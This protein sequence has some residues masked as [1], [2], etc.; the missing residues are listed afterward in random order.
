M[1]QT[2]AD[3]AL[4]DGRSILSYIS[5]TIDTETARAAAITH[6]H[7]PTDVCNLCN[8]FKVSIN[9]LDV[10]DPV[11]NRS[12]TNWLHQFFFLILTPDT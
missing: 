3:F 2:L 6:I 5:K 11:D 4:G 8:H 1:N 12:S 10:V 7:L 9:K